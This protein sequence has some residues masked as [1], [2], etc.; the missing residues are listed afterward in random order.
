[1]IAKRVYVNAMTLKGA[2]QD[3]AK[4]HA[5]DVFA[6]PDIARADLEVINRDPDGDPLFK[7]F[8]IT[9]TYVASRLP[10]PGRASRAR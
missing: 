10:V 9:V 2:E 5:D 6:T 3:A 1:M 7:T 4:G 8:A